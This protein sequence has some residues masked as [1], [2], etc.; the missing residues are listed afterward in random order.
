M[1]NLI[2]NST[3]EIQIKLKNQYN[4]SVARLR[5]DFK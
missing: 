5:V 1:S 2:R 4:K 3:I